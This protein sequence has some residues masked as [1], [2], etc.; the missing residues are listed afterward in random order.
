MICSLQGQQLGSLLCVGDSH[1]RL[2]GLKPPGAIFRYGRVCRTMVE[3]FDQSHVLSLRGAT[4][5]GFHPKAD[6]D[7][8]YSR[9]SRCIERLRP[10]TI[11]FGFG[12]VDAELGCYYQALRDGTRIEDVIR[13]KRRAMQRYLRHCLSM[14]GERRILIKGLNTVALRSTRSLRMMIG[15]NLVPSL[16]IPARDLAD[17]LELNGV[18]L[19]LHARINAEIATALRRSAERMG[20]PYFDLRAVTGTQRRAGL[21]K[22][23]FS[24]R[25]RDV[26][27]RDLNEIETRFARSLSDAVMSVSA[28]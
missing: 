28:M 26:H 25:S 12:Q 7:C 8:S 11:C 10:D 4:A 27:L 16:D 21:S 6:P 17:W 14:A 9:V 2:I 22:R 20:L 5:A 15:H 19:A 18:T 1:S 3:G 13:L 24:S 23:A